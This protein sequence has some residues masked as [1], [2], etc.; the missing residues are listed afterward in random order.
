MSRD[1]LE[2]QHRDQLPC[3]SS[4]GELKIE[5]EKIRG[6]LFASPQGARLEA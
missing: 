4:C 2:Y 1:E 3:A 5:P 6:S